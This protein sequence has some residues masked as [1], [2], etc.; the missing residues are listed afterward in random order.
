LRG[1]YLG[2]RGVFWPVLRLRSVGQGKIP[3]AQA[4]AQL[5]LERSELRD[6]FRQD[7]RTFIEQAKP[8][9]RKQVENLLQRQH[10]FRLTYQDAAERQW[11]FTVLHG[12]IRL[13]ENHQYLVC[14][15]EETEGNQDIAELEHNWSL[16]LDRITEAAIAPLNTPWQPLDQIPVTF[17]LLRGLA[18]AYAKGEPKPD[19]LTVG[20]IEGDPPSRVVE[21][22]I[23]STFW[24]FREIR[25]YGADCE[26]IAPESV[27][28]R[29]QQQLQQMCEQYDI[30]I[31]ATESKRNPP[32][33]E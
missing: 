24:F 32:K 10:P 15:C 28:S 25:Q 11:T 6:Y 31:A 4:I 5:L 26:I 29:F 8:T 14:T 13:I 17:R 33:K 21:R 20:A 23:F 1:F 7:L 9:W 22:Q 12:Q 3:E 2:Q 16:R 18:F 27:R 19:D 30:A